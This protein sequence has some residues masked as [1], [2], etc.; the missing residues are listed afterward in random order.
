MSCHFI[1]LLYPNLFV[2]V[3]IN[4]IFLVGVRVAA[5]FHTAWIH[6]RQS[7]TNAQIARST[8]EHISHIDVLDWRSNHKFWQQPVYVLSQA[9]YIFHALCHGVHSL[10]TF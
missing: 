7:N 1:I 3:L 8:L 10:D 5:A 9:W 6:A 2:F 4:F